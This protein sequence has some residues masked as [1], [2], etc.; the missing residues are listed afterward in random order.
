MI[1]RLKSKQENPDGLPVARIRPASRGMVEVRCPKTSEP[2]VLDGDH[3]G[4][5]FYNPISMEFF[6][7]PNVGLNESGRVPANRPSARQT[8]EP[9]GLGL[10]L[11]HSVTD[12]EDEG[13]KNKK[14][15]WPFS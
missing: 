2:L 11:D 7:I 13:K 3:T 1:P 12:A 10:K 4:R 14:G 15:W 8:A 6:W 9:Q 5:K